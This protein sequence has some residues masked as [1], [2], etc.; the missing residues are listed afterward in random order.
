[1]LPL[2][3]FI[4]TFT[5]ETR[6]KNDWGSPV[7]TSKK[8]LKNRG[9]FAYLQKSKTLNSGKPKTYRRSPEKPMPFSHGRCGVLAYLRA[10]GKNPPEDI[11]ICCTKLA[12]AIGQARRISGF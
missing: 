1:M 5:E 12:D 3:F 11:V 8:P 10:R 6:E 2:S 9:S 7:F 4:L